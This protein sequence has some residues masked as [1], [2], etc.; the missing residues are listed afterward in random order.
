MDVLKPRIIFANTILPSNQLLPVLT[1]LG[2]FLVQIDHILFAANV[3]TQFLFLA[4]FVIGRL[5]I[6][7]ESQFFEECKVLSAVIACIRYDFVHM[8]AITRVHLGNKGHQSMQVITLL[9][10]HH[11][12][13][14]A[15]IGGELNVVG[16]LELSIAHVIVFHSHEGGI[17]VG[18]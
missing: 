4:L 8:M 15:A 14:E 12:N 2:V 13:D 7:P 17:R 16:R 10:G 18:L 11:A 1:L 9:T 3:L 5:D 6:G